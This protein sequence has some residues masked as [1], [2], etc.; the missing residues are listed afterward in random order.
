MSQPPKPSIID[1]PY[2]FSVA[3]IDSNAARAHV[4]RR[5]YVDSVLPLIGPQRSFNFWG[6]DSF[7]GK[8]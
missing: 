1:E 8:F 2:L 7:F 4:Q 6:K 3:K 5:K